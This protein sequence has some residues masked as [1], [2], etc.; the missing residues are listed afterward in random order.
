VIISVDKGVQFLMEELREHIEA[1]HL[2]IERQSDILTPEPGLTADERKQLQA[3]NRTMEQLS[4]LG[5]SVPE[6]LRNLK[7]RLSTKDAS[8]AENREVEERIIKL[9]AFIE[10]LQQLSQAALALRNRLKPTGHTG[11]TRRSYGVTLLD[12][13]QSKHL[14]TE[15]T[16]ELQ[17]RKDGPTYEGKSQPDGSLMVKT[18]SGWQKYVSLSAAAVDLAGGSLTKNG[19]RHW[20]RINSDGSRTRL[21]ELRNRFISDGRTDEIPKTDHREL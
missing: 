9:E 2:W 21:F 6:D 7:L 5:V 10:Q 11:G 16:L 13:L 14:S 19:W 4:R 3:V 17:W 12:L 15:D 8:G 1:M 18:P 20:K